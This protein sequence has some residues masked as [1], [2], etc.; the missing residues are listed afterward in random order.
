MTKYTDTE[1]DKML[2]QLA[3]STRSPRGRFSAEE[4][5]K[6]LQ[7]RLVKVEDK[8][9]KLRFS[10]RWATIAAIVM[11]A[12]LSWSIYQYML[13]PAMQTIE[14]LSQQISIELSDGSRVTLNHYSSLTYP[15]RFKGDRRE[16]TLSGEGYFEVAKDQSKPFVVNAQEINVEV[17][18]TVFNIEAYANNPDVVT[19]LF[20][21]SVAVSSDVCD[22][23]IVLSPDQ[24]AIYNKA[25]KTLLLETLELPTNAIVWQKGIFVFNK[26]PLSEIARKLGNSF[27]VSIEIAEHDLGDYHLTA[28]F[29]NGESLDEILELLQSG[30]DFH[31]QKLDEKQYIIKNRL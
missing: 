20:E 17:L 4:S 2:E 3:G 24:C 30:R 5:F 22:E 18:G 13:P 12:A 26:Q 9:W 6:L 23:R 8:R 16:V 19:T 14:T 25:N 29:A 31:F 11:I 1:R 27:G 15:K 28:R 7:P 21:G 10:S